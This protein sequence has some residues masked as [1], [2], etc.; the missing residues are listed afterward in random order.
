[1]ARHRFL[2]DEWLEAVDALIDRFGTEI[3]PGAEVAINVTVTDTPFGTTLELHLSA[4]GGRG[5]WKRG[6]AEAADV[7]LTTDYATSKDVFV[8]TEPAAGMQAFLSGKVRVQGDMA[9]LLAAQ[10]AAAEV[11]S[12][13]TS[14]LQL[15][16][17]D[18]TE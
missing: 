2:S 13:Q 5:T 6:H 1:M 8:S 14:E 18:L 7:T 17:L 3:P 9:K 16:I 11:S 12:G 10:A 15:A 4:A